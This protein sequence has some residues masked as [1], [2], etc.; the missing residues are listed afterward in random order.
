[1]KTATLTVVLL[2]TALTQLSFAQ[3]N[4]PSG[5]DMITQQAVDNLIAGI[6]SN[7]E[8]LQKSSIYFAGLYKVKETVA[9]LAKTLFENENDN[10][11]LL[12]AL[13]LYQIQDK[14]GMNALYKAAKFGDDSKVKNIC[15][16]MYNSYV[17]S[18]ESEY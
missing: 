2:F 14:E 15:A 12:A 11:Q 4:S 13:S 9:P 8:G 5:G 1:M 6:N 16:A 10:I 3:K 7:N 17:E 18:G